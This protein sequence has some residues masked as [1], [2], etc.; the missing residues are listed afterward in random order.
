MIGIVFHSG[1]TDG[2]LHVIGAIMTAVSVWLLGLTL[3]DRMLHRTSSSVSLRTA[4]AQ[5]AS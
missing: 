3:A 4:S 1:V 5:R 2:G